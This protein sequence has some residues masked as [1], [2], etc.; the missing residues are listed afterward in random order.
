MS[1]AAPSQP[2]HA[3]LILWALGSTERE[4]EYA[5]PEEPVQQ[6]SAGTHY[7]VIP[8]HLKQRLPPGPPPPVALRPAVPP[9][10]PPN[11]VLGVKSSSA[12]S[13]LAQVRSPLRFSEAAIIN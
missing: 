10:L 1:G 12:H 3:T 11:P 6:A 13:L 7:G 8:A 5:V 4:S 9:P 2:S